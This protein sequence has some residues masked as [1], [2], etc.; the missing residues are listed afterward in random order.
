VRDLAGWLV[1]GGVFEL[2]E[3]IFDLGAKLV[4]LQDAGAKVCGDG[5]AG[6]SGSKAEDLRLFLI[7][8]NR[9]CATFELGGL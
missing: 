6:L 7:Q 8:A 9:N 3:G 4:G 2:C 1:G 5:H